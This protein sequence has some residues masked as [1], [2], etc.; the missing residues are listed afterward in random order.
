[1]SGAG[2]ALLAQVPGGLPAPLLVGRGPA[3]QRVYQDNPP[4]N[5]YLLTEMGADF[6]SV[7]TA[8]LARGDR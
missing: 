5:E 1:M 8:M 4:R 6:F 7:L 2:G 3:D